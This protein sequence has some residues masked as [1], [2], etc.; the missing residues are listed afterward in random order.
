MLEVMRVQM[1]EALEMG[2]FVWAIIVTV[3]AVA[4]VVIVIYMQRKFQKSILAY[5]ERIKQKDGRSLQAGINFTRGELTEVLASFKLLT[6]YNQIALFSSVSKAFS[7]DLMGIK[8]D[9]VDF[10][11]VKTEGT[12][13]SKD[14]NRVKKLIDE[15][16]VRYRIVEGDIPKFNIKDRELKRNNKKK[17]E[18]E[19]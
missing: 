8:E 4:L 6:E 14:E 16:Q 5:D 17:T 3:I 11:E 7:I 18:N 9:S 1:S 12:R 10:I 15:K 2:Y 19:E 13:L